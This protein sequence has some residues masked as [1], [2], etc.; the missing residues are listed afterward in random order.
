MRRTKPLRLLLILFALLLGLLLLISC[1]PQDERIGAG[2]NRSMPNGD[3]EAGRELLSAWGCGSC[4]HI[5]GVVGAK[6]YVGPPLDAWAERQ[7]IAGTLENTPEN[8]IYW[9]MNPQ[10]VEPGTAM[11][12]T[13]VSEPTARDMAA[14]LYTLEP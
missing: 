10:D 12:D 4:H 1:E 5:P 9:I 13:G 2:S 14:Y 11:P 3:A 6:A 7:F 8:L